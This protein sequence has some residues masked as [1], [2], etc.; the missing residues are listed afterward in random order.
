MDPSLEK[1]KSFL[2]RLAWFLTVVGIAVF[3]CRKALSTLMPF[4][5]A[6][7]VALILQP[8][9]RLLKKKLRFTSGP[10]AV[11]CVLLFY[12]IV[13][14]LLLLIGGELFTTV[15]NFILQAPT[16]YATRIEP[17][18]N[19]LSTSIRALFERVDP[20]TAEFVDGYLDSVG[21]T[22]SSTVSNVSLT[23]VRKIGGYAISL[24]TFLLHV[25]ITVIATVFV[26]SDL[27]KLKHWVLCQLSDENRTLVQNIFIHL[28][29]TL[30]NYVRGYGLILLITFLELCLGL[31]LIGIQNWALLSFGIALLDILPVVG[32]GTVLIPWAIVCV[33]YGEYRSAIAL[34]VVYLIIL[35]VRNFIEPKIVGSRVGLHPIVTLSAMIIG[36]AVFGPV[37]LLGLPITMALLVSLNE[38]G[39]IHIFKPVAAGDTPLP[40]AEPGPE[41]PAP[42][43]KPEPE[44][45]APEATEP[46]RAAEAPAPAKKRF[47]E[48]EKQMLN[49]TA[50]A[51]KALFTKR[52][53][54]GKRKK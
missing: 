33:F 6:F 38:A 16:L 15:K 49:K 18:L 4:I 9:I 1:K 8:P 54:P 36:T 14:A 31:W 52:S 32:T 2:I 3:I 45:P 35:V 7:V 22:L 24:P 29:R 30:S 25:L 39:C 34:M 48:I 10:A 47:F 42:E 20:S 44:M 21:A 11:L 51:A 28:G 50:D 53:K 13:A 43:A 5:I 41:A 27:G 46:E 12:V 23:L 40:E 37:G 19:E 26:S 17:M